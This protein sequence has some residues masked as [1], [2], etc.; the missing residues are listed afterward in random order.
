MV[1]TRWIVAGNESKTISHETLRHEWLSLVE[2]NPQSTYEY[3]PDI[4]LLPGDEPH[5]LIAWGY[6]E[7]NALHALAL[8]RAKTMIFPWYPRAQSGIS[9]SGQRL[10]GASLLGRSDATVL[11][12]FFSALYTL[13]ED[14]SCQF[15]YLEG[16]SVDSHFWSY[17]KAHEHTL[18]F[19]NVP[20]GEIQPRWRIH[21]PENKEDYWQKFSGKSRQNLRRKA[22]KLPHRLI[23]L[24]STD[25]IG[26]FLEKARFISE[27]SWQGK[28]LGLRIT[29]SVRER[30]FF[31]AL[32]KHRAFRA[33]LLESEGTPIAFQFGALWNNCYYGEETAFDLDYAK[34]SPGQTLHLEIIEDLIEH[35]AVR[36]FDFGVGD[37]EYKQ[38]FGN[39]QSHCVSLLLLPRRLSIPALKLA[40]IVRYDQ[41]Q[42]LG[43]DRARALLMQ[44]GWIGKV[45]QWYRGRL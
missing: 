40:A 45:R 14:P 36:W 33:Y 21:L 31:E 20:L 7:H 28:R 4:A 38:L 24:Q 22:R 6:R 1:S 34:H 10:I 9:L 23:K 17:L 3:H 39:E 8:F 12:A 26:L 15:I 18:P 35:E 30:H 13:T 2:A 32:A 42:K 16:L 19:R 41:L 43:E 44:K 37:A 25:E 29:N 5:P 11:R 27:R